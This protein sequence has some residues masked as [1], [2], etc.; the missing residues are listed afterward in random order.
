MN[1]YRHLGLMLVLLCTA[2]SLL[3]QPVAPSTQPQ[4]GLF[5]RVCTKVLLAPLSFIHFCVS[6]YTFIKRD[7]SARDLVSSRNEID[8]YSIEILALKKNKRT[9]LRSKTKYQA[10]FTGFDLYKVTDKAIAAVKSLTPTLLIIT[11]P[12]IAVDAGPIYTLK[13][14]TTTACNYE[15]LQKDLIEVFFVPESETLSSGKKVAVGAA[16]IGLAALVLLFVIL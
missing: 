2:H 6:S 15:Q 4:E 13:A 14:F 8:S 5:S 3:A 16:P 10:S 9:I 7:Q 1:N 11:K 12:F